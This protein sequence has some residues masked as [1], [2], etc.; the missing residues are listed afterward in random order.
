MWAT[1]RQ[2]L[3]GQPLV[4][5][6]RRGHLDALVVVQ[7]PLVVAVRRHQPE[8]RRLRLVGQLREEG[9]LRRDLNFHLGLL[10]RVGIGDLRRAHLVPARRRAEQAQAANRVHLWRDG[11][12]GVGAGGARAR[13]AAAACVSRA[14]LACSRVHPL[15]P[16]ENGTAS[17]GI[18]IGPI[19]ETQHEISVP[20]VSC[21]HFSAI[22]PA[23]TRPIVSRADERPPPDEARLPYLSWY[24]K[25]ACPGRGIS[26]ISL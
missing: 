17:S 11:E 7:F 5:I 13:E 12:G 26:D 23:A 4:E 20:Y 16:R 1:E 3:I 14:C 24:V 21:S 19:D 6:G 18:L 8:L 15:P 9:V 2:Q 10:A 22:A 25:S